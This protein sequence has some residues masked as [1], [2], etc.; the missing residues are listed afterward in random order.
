[1]KKLLTGREAG[2]ERDNCLNWLRLKY[3]TFEILHKRDHV[4]ELLEH[5]P[6]PCKV[7]AHIGKGS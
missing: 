4:K 6:G 3:V 1:M 2:M 5:H 7:P